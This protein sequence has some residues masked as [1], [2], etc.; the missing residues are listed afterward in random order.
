MALPQKVSG[1][2]IPQHHRQ[3]PE[4]QVGKQA[5]KE[6]AAAAH[7]GGAGDKGHQIA[8]RD[9]KLHLCIP[10][11]TDGMEEFMGRIASRA[12]RIPMG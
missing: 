6:E 1:R 11:E 2:K 5:H 9:E 10:G 8:G 12:R 3:G 4:Y 7:G